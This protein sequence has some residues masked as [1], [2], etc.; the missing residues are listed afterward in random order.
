MKTKTTDTH[1]YF[2]TDLHKK[3]KALAKKNRRTISAEAVI[4][5][6]DHVRESA[7][8]SEEKK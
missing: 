6:E 4:A 2:P 3:L 7:K 5:I 1:I 8:Q